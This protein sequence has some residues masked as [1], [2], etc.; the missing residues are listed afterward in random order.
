M[1]KNRSFL[2]K[3][4]LI[5]SQALL[6][7]TLFSCKKDMLDV[8]Y[9][10]QDDLMSTSTTTTG[11]TLETISSNLIYEETFEGS[12]YFPLSGTSLNKTHNI[13]NC[14]EDAGYSDPSLAWTLGA[15]TNP[16]YKGQKSVRFEIR[17]DQPLVGTGEKI[18][19]EVT[20]I[21]GTEDSRF[22]K[23]IWYSFA[24]N[25][26]SVGM[27]YDDT[28]DCIN[29]WFEDGSDET[30]IRVEKDKAFLEV[31]PPEG[32]SSLK[33]YDLFTPSIGTAG[34]VTT[35]TLT[36]FTSIPKN[37]WNEFVFHFIHS[38]GSDGLIEVWRNG[39]KIHH[40]TGRNMHLMLPKWKVGLYK[41]SFLSGESSRSS[42]VIYFD[43]IRVGKA[44]SSLADMISG[45][46][47]GSTSGTTDGITGG[48]TDATSGGTSIGSSTGTST[49]T[50]TQQSGSFILIDSHT[51]KEVKTITN[52]A[53]I[54]LS[55]LGLSKVNI[56]Y[57][58]VTTTQ[59]SVRFVLGGTQNKVYTDNKYPFALHGDDGDGNYYYG[60]WNPPAL[61]TYT[62]NA[63]AYS[64]DYAKGT[65]VS[66]GAI[67]F[68]IVK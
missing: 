12:T 37:Q 3:G 13:E 54:S 64:E 10:G 11:G 16:F 32:S 52:G 41:A 18:R 62:L 49:G 4:K 14:Y 40:I 35:S 58:P 44:G 21:K 15:V 46:T 45:T 50:S 23:D 19:S 56:R 7:A 51:E 27:E 36:S 57:N 17:K 1:K 6:L 68:T 25:F 66:S 38:T 61:G 59:S 26:P 20:I 31:T 53:T 67:T 29:Q 65:V 2:S 55:A 39:V 60:N 42:R 43:N 8:P 33:K 34:N 9:S 63:T 28:R 22:T 24:V 30:T 5:L 47:S 48:T